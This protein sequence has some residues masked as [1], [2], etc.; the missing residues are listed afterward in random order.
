MSV[1]NANKRPWWQDNLGALVKAASLLVIVVGVIWGGGA[2]MASQDAQAKNAGKALEKIE[3]RVDHVNTRMTKT[4]EQ[5]KS[6]SRDTDRIYKTAEKLESAVTELKIIT[7][8]LQT[9][10]MDRDSR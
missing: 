8:E 2:W 10:I 4:E 9:V 3:S 5:I 1:W 7:H 6:L